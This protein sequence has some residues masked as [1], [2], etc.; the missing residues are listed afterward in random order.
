VLGVVEV[1]LCTVEEV[2]DDELDVRWIL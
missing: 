1:G 2:L